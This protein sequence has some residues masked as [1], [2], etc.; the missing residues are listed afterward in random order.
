MP[1]EADISEPVKVALRTRFKRKLS[2][3]EPAHKTELSAQIRGRLRE[4]NFVR[5]AGCVLCY[6]PLADEP[7]IWPW[8]EDRLVEGRRVALLRFEP[9]MEE[10]VAVEVRGR[11]GE[12]GIGRFGVREPSAS[13]PVVQWNQ[14]DLVLV[15]GLGFDL[16]GGRLGRGRGFYDRLLAR[17]VGTACGVAFEE[18]L[19]AEL[20][21][22]AHD[23]GLDCLVTPERLLSFSSSGGG[24]NRT[25]RGD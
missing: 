3:I 12:M 18:Q 13:C 21:C 14:L 8:V 25:A 11:D 6:S 7:D 16:S 22:E 23:V 5:E 1:Q 2:A 20:P 15:P 4:F 10:Y 24:R 9:T 19:C 17:V